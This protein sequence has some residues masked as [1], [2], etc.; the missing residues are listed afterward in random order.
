MLANTGARS[1]GYAN[2]AE[3]C[4][5]SELH[6]EHYD[7]QADHVPTAAPPQGQPLNGRP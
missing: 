3:R 1:G 2:A 6:K 5:Y 4:R 7:A